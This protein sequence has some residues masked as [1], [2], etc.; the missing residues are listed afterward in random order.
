MILLIA[1]LASSP[2]PAESRQ[3]VLSV[4]EGWDAPRARVRLYERDRPATPWRPVAP[5]V[6]ASLGRTGL[7]WGRGLQPEGLDGPLKKEGDGKSPAG[8]FELREATGYAETL[9]ETR[10]RYRQATEPLKCVDDPAS[11]SYN[12]LVDA[13]TVGKDWSSAEEMRRKDDL[14]RLVVWVGH[15]DRPVT[16]GAGSCIFLHLRARADAVTDGCTAFDAEP[17]D[18]LMRFLDP[19]LRPVLVQLPA[20]AFRALGGDWGLPAAAP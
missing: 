2:V 8:I 10:L 11:A 5:A 19:A 12:R 6:T 17:M 18:R 7:A 15:N 16:K 14:Y 13:T 3:L 4:G 1:L 20:G 9:P